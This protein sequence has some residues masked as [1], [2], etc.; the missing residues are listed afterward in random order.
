M[1]NHANVPTNL[2][3]ISGS[4][5]RVISA[6]RDSKYIMNTI[7]HVDLKKICSNVTLLVRKRNKTKLVNSVIYAVATAIYAKDN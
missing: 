5:G 6:R 3:G 7:F 2:G 4:T 1:Q